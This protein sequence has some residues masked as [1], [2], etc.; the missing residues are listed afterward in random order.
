M[1]DALM[2]LTCWAQGSFAGVAWTFGH[3]PAAATAAA[4]TVP[5]A[6]T[7]VPTAAAVAV[8][9]AA[10]ASAA[11]TAADL[12]MEPYKPALMVSAFSTADGICTHASM[13]SAK[14]IS[15]GSVLVLQGHGSCGNMLHQQHSSE[16]A[17]F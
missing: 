3:P 14:L 7:V 8:L 9:A 6:E 17:V 13:A 12:I 16:V 1:Q 15:S 5:A 2:C 4:A 11:A 10:S